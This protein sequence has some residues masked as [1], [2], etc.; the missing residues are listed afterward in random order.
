MSQKSFKLCMIVPA[1]HLTTVMDVVKDSADLISMEQIATPG[2]APKRKMGFANGKRVKGTTARDLIITT[3]SDGTV[4]TRAALQ[5]LFS[6]N[7]FAETSVG[8]A[9][10]ELIRAGNV[11]QISPGVYQRVGV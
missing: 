6:A 3:L 5:K 2:P 4:K 8:P 1:E 11:S 7:G 9:V 10:N